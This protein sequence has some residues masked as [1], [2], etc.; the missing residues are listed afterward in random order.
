M[1]R[2]ALYMPVELHEKLQKI[3]DRED[4]TMVLQLKHWLDIFG[5]KKV[6]DSTQKALEELGL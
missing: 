6:K 5:P 1:K 3:A 2:K 4:R